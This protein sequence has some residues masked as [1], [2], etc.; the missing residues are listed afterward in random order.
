MTLNGNIYQGSNID[1][2][3][4][5]SYGTS[6]TADFVI[7]VKPGAATKSADHDHGGHPH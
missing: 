6:L 5:S 3:M 7:D 1:A 2:P 4:S